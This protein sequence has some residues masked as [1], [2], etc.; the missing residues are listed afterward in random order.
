M[1]HIFQRGVG[2]I[3]TSIDIVSSSY[4]G[5]IGVPPLQDGATDILNWFYIVYQQSALIDLAMQQVSYG[6]GA[7]SWICVSN[8]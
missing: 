7:L 4:R 2:S 3:P 1:T 8:S 6:T 5:P